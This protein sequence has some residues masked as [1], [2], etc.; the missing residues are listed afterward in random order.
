MSR[1]D[2]IRRDR[3]LACDRDDE[4]SLLEAI[5]GLQSTDDPSLCP[6]HDELQARFAELR[7]GKRAREAAFGAAQKPFLDAIIANPAD[8]NVRLVFA[9]WLQENGQEERAEFIRVQ[10]ELATLS[11]PCP[12]CHSAYLR[13]AD[14]N[15]GRYTPDLCAAH[16]RERELWP[17]TVADWHRFGWPT[18]IPF[19]TFQP[20]LRRGFVERVTCTAADW[21]AHAD[22][23]RATHPVT[24]V[25]LTTWPGEPGP[26]LESI[27]MET[28]LI[29][30]EWCGAAHAEIVKVPGRRARI[31][32]NAERVWSGVAFELPDWRHTPI[33][34]LP[35]LPHDPPVSGPWTPPVHHS[36][37]APMDPDPS[38]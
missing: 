17:S 30:P 36:I 3:A 5:A 15:K 23:I 32:A 26:I 31:K 28:W 38:A 4:A 13:T 14:V 18:D 11:D 34:S 6:L 9:D 2:R 8:D 16:Q 24:R 29:P 10:C 19:P 35:D 20:V 25:R 1:H 22:A 12:R 37:A 33:V 21:L 7:Q 27:Q